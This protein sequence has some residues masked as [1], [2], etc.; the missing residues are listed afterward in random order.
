MINSLGSE[1]AEDAM[2]R[3]RKEDLTPEQD[4]YLTFSHVREYKAVKGDLDAAKSALRWFEQYG[5]QCIMSKMTGK[6]CPAASY[7]IKLEP[8]S[9]SASR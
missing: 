6:P 8:P 2:A 1:R 9:R 3:W 7:T 5:E 4:A